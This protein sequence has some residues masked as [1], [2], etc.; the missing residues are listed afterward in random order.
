MPLHMQHYSM[1]AMGAMGDGSCMEGGSQHG[2]L[3]SPVKT[4]LASQ[5]LLSLA[6]RGD[7]SRASCIGGGEA[8]GSMLLVGTP[9]AASRHSYGHMGHSGSGSAGLGSLGELDLAS[10]SLGMEPGD[11]YSESLP[12]GHSM[13]DFES[14]ASVTAEA[15]FRPSGGETDGK[16]NPGGGQVQK[17]ENLAREF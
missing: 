8:A 5:A 7:L 14:F 6:T 17:P 13:A 15:L 2:G 1:G 10:P 11:R 12:P 3:P 4:N 16:W 9:P